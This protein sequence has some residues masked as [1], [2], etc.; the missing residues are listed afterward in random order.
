MSFSLVENDLTLS[1]L[2]NQKKFVYCENFFSIS[3]EKKKKQNI[4]AKF[5]VSFDSMNN[6]L[7]LPKPHKYERTFSYTSLLLSHYLKYLFFFVWRNPNNLIYS[8]NLFT[9][10]FSVRLLNPNPSRKIPIRLKSVLK[11]NF[12]SIGFND[13]DPLTDTY[14]QSNFAQNILLNIQ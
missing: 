6:K 4:S 8:F 3:V 12:Q 9:I 10:D 2:K 1:F 7:I 11:I 5:L 14:I 13:I